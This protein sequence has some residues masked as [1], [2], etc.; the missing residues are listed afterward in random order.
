MFDMRVALLAHD[1]ARREPRD[2]MGAQGLVIVGVGRSGERGFQML[3]RF[4]DACERLEA[5]GTNVIFVYPK[6]SA[7]HVLDPVS[8]SSAQIRQRPCLFLDDEGRFFQR[9]CPPR[10]LALVHLSRDMT[11][12]D[13]AKIVLHDHAWADELLAF[14]ARAQARVMH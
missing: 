10:S 1:Y 11:P 2:V 5:L 9:P 8:V 4:S 14:L 3:Y 6:E 13:T 12:L 7:R